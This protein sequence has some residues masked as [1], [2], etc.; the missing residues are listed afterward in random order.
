[1]RN[2]LKKAAKEIALEFGTDDVEGILDFMAGTCF[3]FSQCKEMQGKEE[4]GS[5]A[6]ESLENLALVAKKLISAFEELGPVAKRTLFVG[7]NG[8]ESELG[9]LDQRLLPDPFTTNGGCGWVDQLTSLSRHAQFSAW[10]VQRVSGRG[11]RK[12]FMAHSGGPTPE[13]ELVEQCWRLADAYGCKSQA[14]V[15]RMMRAILE[16]ENGKESMK[17]QDGRPSLDK[18]RK[19][20][21]KVAQTKRK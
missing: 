20:V 2:E 17:R 1:M 16:V 8:T 5:E 12:S 11:G 19:A 9:V 10:I 6:R 15:H 3:Y 4:L 21:R 18:G 14:V 13:G 7:A